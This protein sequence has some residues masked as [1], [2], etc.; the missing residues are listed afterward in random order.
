MAPVFLSQVRPR[1]AQRQNEGAEL[2]RRDD[3][4]EEEGENNGGR[5]GGKRTKCNRSIRWKGVAPDE[6][7]PRMIQVSVPQ[8][9]ETR[10]RIS[11]T[12]RVVKEKNR[13]RKLTGQS[14][15]GRRKVNQI[16]IRT[17]PEMTR[18]LVLARIPHPPQAQVQVHLLGGGVEKKRAG[19]RQLRKDKE[20]VRRS[21]ISQRKTDPRYM[22]G[23]NRT[24]QL[25]LRIR[26]MIV[27]LRTQSWTGSCVP[28]VCQRRTKKSSR[29]YC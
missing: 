24:L 11:G 10:R 3:E 18:I 23:Q 14:L 19:R 13:K 25:E 9:R 2:R 21:V 16:Q 29:I 12:E 28:M 26:Y 20:K 22:E 4:A 8:M 17:R 7:P 6:G 1:E 27:I 15:I 5:E